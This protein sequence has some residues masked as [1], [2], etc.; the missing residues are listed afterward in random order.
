M[1]EYGPRTQEQVQMPNHS[2]FEQ[3]TYKDQSPLCWVSI[4]F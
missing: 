4:T 3:F 1:T 2:I